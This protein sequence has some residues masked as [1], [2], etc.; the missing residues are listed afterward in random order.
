MNNVNVEVGYI[1]IKT[2][3]EKGDYIMRKIYIG[4]FF[5]IDMDTEEKFSLIKKIGFD[6]VMLWWG[7]DELDGPKD[8]RVELIHR[9]GLEVELMH[10]HVEETESL[11]EFGTDGDDVLKRYMQCVTDCK[12]NGIK[13][14]VMHPT[15][16]GAPPMTSFALTRFSKLLEHA[17]KMGVNIAFE[18]LDRPEYLDYIFSNINSKRAKFCFDS[19]HRNCYSKDVNLLSKYSDRLAGVHFHDNRGTRDIHM[20]PG[21][22][23]INWDKVMDG[24]SKSVYDGPIVLEVYAHMSE[25][26]SKLTPEEFLVDAYNRAKKLVFLERT[27]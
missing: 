4:N 1:F 3:D 15:D 20:L 27:K 18:N 14:M 26:Y 23:N 17:E 2:K 7:E 9:H 6:G 10:S 13:T 24:V 11:W 16:G 22:G 25:I 8:K 19:G 5:G 21:D 12:D